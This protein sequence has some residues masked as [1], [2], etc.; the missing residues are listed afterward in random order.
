MKNC[1][2]WSPAVVCGMKC[3]YLCKNTTRI[4]GVHL[5]YNKTKQDEKIILE[6]RIIVFKTL[7]ISK[8]VYLSLVIKARNEI[9]NELEK[10]QKRFI[11][12]P[13]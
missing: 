8:I 1:R 7:A 4:T 3:V 5:S 9:I 10:I 2:I 12:P 6:G 11:W 13:N